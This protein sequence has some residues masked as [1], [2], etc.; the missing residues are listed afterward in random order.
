MFLPSVSLCCKFWLGCDNIY[1]RQYSWLGDIGRALSKPIVAADWRTTGLP[2]LSTSL[3]E[4]TYVAF[5]LSKSQ[6][7]IYIV[8]GTLPTVALMII[9]L[10]KHS[11]PPG[12]KYHRDTSHKMPPAGQIK[13]LH[14]APPPQMP[15]GKGGTRKDKTPDTITMQERQVEQKQAHFEKSRARKHKF[16]IRGL[17]LT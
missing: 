7:H 9:H 6:S 13:T 8:D 1:N 4:I 16:L 12:Q 3:R 5:V 2:L 11:Y 10:S 15:T 14:P 17:V